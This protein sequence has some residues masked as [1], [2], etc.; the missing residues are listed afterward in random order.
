M[1]FDKSGSTIRSHQGSRLNKL[2]NGWNGGDNLS[3]LQFVQN[4]RFSCG[5]KTN[6]KKFY[7]KFNV[8]ILN[9]AFD[10][11]IKIRICFLPKRR[12]N[13]LEMVNPIISNFFGQKNW[14][15]FVSNQQARNFQILDR[16]RNSRFVQFRKAQIFCENADLTCFQ[17]DKKPRNNEFLSMCRC[18][19]STPYANSALVVKMYGRYL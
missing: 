9:D 1:T 5:V 7:V 8:K 2:T 17:G 3:K 19:Q 14:Q 13:K 11:P 10:L 15:K 6:C 4:C 16:L 18:S 12:P